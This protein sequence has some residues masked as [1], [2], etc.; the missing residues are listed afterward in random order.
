MKF[1]A[2]SRTGVA[3]ALSTVLAS[4]ATPVLAQMS[5]LPSLTISPSARDRM[6]MRL[7]YVYSITK[8]TS[9]EAYDVTGPVVTIRDLRAMQAALPT[10]AGDPNRYRSQ[11]NLA[12]SVL[13]DYLTKDYG[14]APG[15]GSLGTPSGI[16]ARAGNAGTI[17]LSIGYYFDDEQSYALEALILGAPLKLSVYGDGVNETGNPNGVNGK[18]L[19]TTKM[20]P[21]TVMLGKYFGKKDDVFRPYV[22]VG[23]M[24]AIFFDTKATDFLN[25]FQGGK[26]SV[27]TKNAFGV[28]PFVGFKVEAG[29]GWH[30]SFN[31]GQVSLKSQATLVTRD[32]KITSSSAV[33]KEYGANTQFA[34]ENGEFLYASGD[35]ANGATNNATV[36]NRMYPNGFVTKMMQD[37]AAYKGG[38]LGTF[39]RK[40]DNRFDNTIL[41]LSVGRSF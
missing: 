19:I 25:D 28:G 12:I 11:Y 8:T 1:P 3:L 23:A 33:L 14:Y 21:P 32:T 39:V 20:L 13:D 5:G 7:N 22:G 17:A 36:A 10:G 6:Y 27:S 16:R 41:M 18:K 2:L 38:S 30:A 29:S 4:V 34:I 35:T 26:T 31:V 9:G 24:Y 15:E 40:Q 37:L